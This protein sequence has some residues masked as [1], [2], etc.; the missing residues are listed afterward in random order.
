MNNKLKEHVAK[1]KT[2]SPMKKGL[3]IIFFLT[4]GIMLYQVVKENEQEIHADPELTP[5]V[6][7]TINA[8]APQSAASAPL[9]Q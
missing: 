5:P 1:F 7:Q 9:G 6:V 2:L 4:V 3:V 8:S